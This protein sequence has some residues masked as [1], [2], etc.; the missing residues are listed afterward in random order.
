MLLL[1]YCHPESESM[2]TVL[3][4]SLRTM[5]QKEPSPLTPQSPPSLRKRVETCDAFCDV[6]CD[7][8]EL[9]G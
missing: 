7:N 2:G 3:F 6:F 1:L 4:D 9:G 5:S 8:L